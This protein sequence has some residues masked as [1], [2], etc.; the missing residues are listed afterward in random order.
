MDTLTVQFEK[1]KQ[2]KVVRNSFY[3]VIQFVVSTL[4]LLGFTPV[5]I[6][7][8]GTEQYGLWMLATSVLGLMV[9]GD[10]GL[11]TAISKFVAEFVESG[12]IDLL[13]TVVSVGLIAYILL[14]F[15][16]I[17]PLYVF[18][19]TLAGI[20]KASET[21]S[22]E[23]IGFVIRII[24]L[25][26]IPLLLRSG[27]VA[28]LVGLQRFKVLVIVMVGSQILVYTAALIIAFLGG[29]VAQVVRSTVAVLWITALASLFLAWQMLQPFRL[30]F[31]L[32]RSGEV[33]RRMFSFS[34][35]S[36]ISGIGTQIFSFVDRLA[37]GAVLGLDALA[38]YTV[39]TSMAAKIL[40][41]NNALT[42]VLMPAVSTWMA[43][44]DIRRVRVYFLRATMALLALNFLIASILLVLSGP[45]LWLWM[46]EAF[47]DHVLVPFRVLIVIYALISLNAPA[48][49]VAYGI[50]KPGINALFDIAGGCL[51]ISLILILGKPLGLL[52][53]TL[54]N[55]GYLIT[56]G[57]IGY[58]YL[59]IWTLDKHT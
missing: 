12:N 29:S 27:A 44:G 18:S 21:V 1:Y 14:G 42:S 34:L 24:F 37:V 35:M 31:A 5:F 45:L 33:V 22:V 55:G 3:G 57:I 43:T 36:G 6:H 25:G 50:G 23:Q 54:A 7:K 56:W 47:A 48:H 4:L 53:A 52:G 9:V 28:V 30:K 17:I 15:G 46:G 11:N 2:N 8:M 51:T 19:P 13:S 40:Q 32:I 26:F 20:F 10:F 16:L 49:F 41:L 39:I 59:H 38:Y 58:I